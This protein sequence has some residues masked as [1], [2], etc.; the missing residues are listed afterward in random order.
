[1][2]PRW[3]RC[4]LAAGCALLIPILIGCGAGGQ[5]PADGGGDRQPWLI[6]DRPDLGRDL[7]DPPPTDAVA[8]D[9]GP[10]N[11]LASSEVGWSDSDTALDGSVTDALCAGIVNA[12][13][14][15]GCTGMNV[16]D[17]T[18]Q[19]VQRFKEFVVPLISTY[20]PRPNAIISGPD[21]NIW[22]GDRTGV[23][24]LALP[25]GEITRF[26]TNKPPVAFANGSDGH[27]WFTDGGSV[28]RI[29]VE[30]R[31]TAFLFDQGAAAGPTGITLGRDGNLWFGGVI[32]RITPKAMVT[33]FPTLVPSYYPWVASGSDGNLWFTG[34]MNAQ[35]ARVTPAGVVTEF[36]IGLQP[37][38]TPFDQSLG[39]I[40]AGPDGNLWFVE[41]ARQRIGRID[42]RGVAVSFP[43]P[44]EIAHLTAGRDGN[45]WFARIDGAALGR[46]TP[47][48]TIT[49]FPISLGAVRH[50]INGLTTDA[51]GAFWF[52]V[53]P[54][55]QVADT[56]YRV[57]RYVP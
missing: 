20:A 3:T 17:R 56:P 29:T 42:T 23:V 2:A 21:G 35:I 15:R 18:Q 25:G 38:V 24:R 27:I 1:M 22:F 28:N 46:I 5:R 30:G 49:E 48:G 31:L 33:V 55:L 14:P 11:D 37:S 10:S 19:C 6:A 50:N 4:F 45:V 7:P 44:H 34:A 57:V 43:V 52:T 26:P 8:G 12:E 39:Q 51:K 13:D 16:C 9:G 53:E 47:D 54:Y 32:G 40:V 36:S 41:Y